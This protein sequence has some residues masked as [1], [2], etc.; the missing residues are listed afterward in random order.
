MLRMIRNEY[1][2][3]SF[4]QVFITRDN[5][6][7]LDPGFFIISEQ[8]ANVIKSSVSDAFS[9]NKSFPPPLLRLSLHQAISSEKTMISLFFEMLSMFL[10]ICSFDKRYFPDLYKEKSFLLICIPTHFDELD[11]IFDILDIPFL[12]KVSLK[13]IFLKVCR[14]NPADGR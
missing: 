13:S 14:C 2:S 3:Y 4:E 12:K 7:K 6:E 1:S 9:L 11:P 8:A 10:L 5:A